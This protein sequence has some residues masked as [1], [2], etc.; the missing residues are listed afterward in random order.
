MAIRMEELRVLQMQI[1]MYC[2]PAGLPL[3]GKES[4]V[5]VLREQALKWEQQIATIARGLEDY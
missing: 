1:V 3:E 5:G 2:N 4:Y